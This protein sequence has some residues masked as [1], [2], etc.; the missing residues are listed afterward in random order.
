[1]QYFG[2]FFFGGGFWSFLAFL[3]DAAKHVI[4]SFLIHIHALSNYFM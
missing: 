1:M 2:V 4:M 3:D